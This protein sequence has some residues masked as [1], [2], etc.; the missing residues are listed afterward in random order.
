MEN[1]YDDIIKKHY[2]TA[3]Q[4]NLVLQAQWLTIS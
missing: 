3:I 1:S 2:D 4:I